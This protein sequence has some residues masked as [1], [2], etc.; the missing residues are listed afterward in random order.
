MF[1]VSDHLLNGAVGSCRRSP[2]RV[3]TREPKRRVPG[4]QLQDRARPSHRYRRCKRP[5]EVT[6]Y[7]R[8]GSSPRRTVQSPATLTGFVV[9]TPTS[10]AK[11]PFGA[12]WK[13]RMNAAA[14]APLAAGS[15]SRRGRKRRVCE[16]PALALTRSGAANGNVRMEGRFSR[17]GLLVMALLKISVLTRDRTDSS[18]HL[19]ARHP[20]GLRARSRMRS[21]ALR[22]FVAMMTPRW[23]HRLRDP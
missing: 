15:A 16:H 13:N 12:Y 4:G 10:T 21:I 22:A 17:R 11:S 6:A 23:E 14:V 1:A 20:N 19:P 8:V 9:V 5:H 3:R 18:N 7:G 2:M